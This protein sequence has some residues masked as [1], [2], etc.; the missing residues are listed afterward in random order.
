MN[1]T[2]DTPNSDAHRSNSGTL[3]VISVLL[4]V[5]NWLALDDITTGTEPSTWM[6][7]TVVATTL[8]WFLLLGIWRFSRRRGQGA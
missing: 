6:E 7:W 5:L 2:A 4:L 1:P 8:L 3:I